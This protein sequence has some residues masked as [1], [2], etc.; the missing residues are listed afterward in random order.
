M[1]PCLGSLS[2]QPPTHHPPAALLHPD[3]LTPSKTPLVLCLQDDESPA[4]P[5]VPASVPPPRKSHPRIEGADPEL[6]SMLER[7]VVEESP[8]VKWDDIAGLQEAKRLLEEAV[9]LPL[10]MPEYFQVRADGIG[11]E[12]GRETWRQGERWRVGRR[13]ES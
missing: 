4:P 7:D 8:G 10:L 9:V 3:L 5:P 2:L 6:V 11:K 13:Q 12:R 1:S